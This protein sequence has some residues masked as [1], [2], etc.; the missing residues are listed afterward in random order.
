MGISM[1]E[2]FATCV[3]E[4]QACACAEGG[5]MSES[6]GGSLGMD[7]VGM[8]IGSVGMGISAEDVG[9]GMKAKGVSVGM[10]A[11]G[12]GV[13]MNPEDVDVGMSAGGVDVGMSAEGI[14]MSG[15][16]IGGVGIGG[17]DIGGVDIGIGAID[18]TPGFKA[19]FLAG[20]FC[21]RP[22]SQCEGSLFVEL[23]WFESSRLRF[24]PPSVGPGHREAGPRAS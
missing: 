10:S 4:L 3:N 20:F 18:T 6:T 14:G 24:W 22:L 9:V 1:V 17:V 15:V 21:L 12:M 7:G 5:G 8:G 16:G 13:G 11:E 19:F 23:S 2:V